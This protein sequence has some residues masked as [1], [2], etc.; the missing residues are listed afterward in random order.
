MTRDDGPGGPAGGLRV[1]L[2]ELAEADEDEFLRMA[3]ASADLHHPWYST[4]ST[5]EEF[6]VY[7]TRLSQPTTE[8]RVVCVRDSGA[9]AGLVALDTIVRGRFQSASIS[10]AAFAPAS[11][12]G[13]LAE[14][15][16]LML[17]YA[18][19]DLRLHRVEASIQ[20]GNEAS[21]RLAQRLGFR[22]EGYS[23]DMLFIDGAWRDHVRWALT[24][25]MTGFPAVDPDP[26]LP[27]R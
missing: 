4:A 17:W 22:Q 12:Q 20:P 8:G 11:G 26:S 23:P 9:M 3:R 16:R 24:R 27:A 21:L 6:R 19:Q 10:Y 25:E 18:F 5:P 7:L 14:G 15:V 2:R 1:R 13:Y